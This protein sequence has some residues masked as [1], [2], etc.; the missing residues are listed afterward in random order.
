MRLVTLFLIAA[1]AA[2]TV[3][4]ASYQKIDST[5]VDPIRYSPYADSLIVPRGEP[6]PY[7]GVNL[8]PKAYQTNANLTCASRTCPTLL[9]DPDWR[10]PDE[11]KFHW[12]HRP[13]FI[14][15]DRRRSYHRSIERASRDE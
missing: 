11:S 9:R 14:G 13:V 3:G 5:I 1:F 6:H 4:A 8:E 7:S 2:A 10:E 12:I 15:I